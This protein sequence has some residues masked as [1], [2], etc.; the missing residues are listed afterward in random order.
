MGALKKCFFAL[1][2]VAIVLLFGCVET[3]MNARDNRT[4]ADAKYCNSHSDCD[5]LAYD[6]GGETTGY[7]LCVDHA[8]EL[9]NNS[10]SAVACTNNT[11]RRDS[12]NADYGRYYFCGAVY[13]S[14][15]P[16]ALPVFKC[17]EKTGV[18]RSSG[19]RC[20]VDAQCV[21]A[22]AQESD[23][24]YNVCHQKT[25]SGYRTCAVEDGCRDNR[26]ACGKVYT[27]P[28]PDGK[29]YCVEPG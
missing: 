25:R 17:L 14:A 22:G 27:R 7:S 24:Y 8:C 4:S 26:F 23:C 29:Y 13:S 6:F 11:G 9:R 20:N 3:T 5:G 15:Q 1:V 10:G 2:A 19:K 21:Y 28:H 18:Q 16:Q 12:C